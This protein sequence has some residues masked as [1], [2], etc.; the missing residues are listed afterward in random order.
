MGSHPEKVGQ[1]LRT[2]YSIYKAR[3]HLG[4]KSLQLEI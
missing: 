4:I 3:A 2:E 1:E